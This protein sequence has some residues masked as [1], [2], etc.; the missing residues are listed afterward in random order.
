MGD[1][2]PLATSAG[3]RDVITSSVGDHGSMVINLC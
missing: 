2:A 3:R 1:A